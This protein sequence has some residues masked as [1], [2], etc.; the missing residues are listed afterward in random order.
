MHHLSRVDLSGGGRWSPSNEVCLRRIGVL[1][2]GRLC[3]VAWSAPRRWATT[4]R[5]AASGRHVTVKVTGQGRQHL[6]HSRTPPPS[7]TPISPASPVRLAPSHTPRT[8]PPPRSRR[9]H[10]RHGFGISELPPPL[11]TPPR[12]VHRQESASVSFLSTGQAFDSRCRS[13]FPSR[14]A[15]ASTDRSRATSPDVPRVHTVKLG[16]CKPSCKHPVATPDRV[17]CDLHQSGTPTRSVRSRRLDPWTAVLLLLAF[18][19]PAAR[20]HR[21]QR[22]L[23]SPSHC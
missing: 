15:S 20:V 14:R 13:D 10:P 12:C 21:C 7:S 17:D 18:P 8:T 23:P 11:P 9:R 1:V 4:G 16:K 5:R 6:L 2:V 19:A 22:P 3:G